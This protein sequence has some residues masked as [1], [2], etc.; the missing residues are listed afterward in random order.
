MSQVEAEPQVRHQ[1][2]EEEVEAV[3]AAEAEAE[4]EFRRSVQEYTQRPQGCRLNTP[5]LRGGRVK[6]RMLTS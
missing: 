4:E 6:M 1:V 5:G 3:E 2:P